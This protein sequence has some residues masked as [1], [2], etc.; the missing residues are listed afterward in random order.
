VAALYLQDDVVT[1]KVLECGIGSGSVE[2]AE[3]LVYPDI[4]AR[5]AGRDPV[6]TV[7]SDESTS[8]PGGVWASPAAE[9]A[10]SS[11]IFEL[12]LAG[13]RFR[14]SILFNT[15]ARS[16]PVNPMALLGGNGRLDTVAEVAQLKC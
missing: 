12:R 5:D 16:V 10:Q 1:V 9:S 7:L 3:L 8:A 14:A 15:S 2:T 6:R 13:D 11:G 4:A